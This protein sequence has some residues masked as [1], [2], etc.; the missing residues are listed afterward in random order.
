MPDWVLSLEWSS[1]EWMTA[2]FIGVV[3]VFVVSLGRSM[4][5]V[6][7]LVRSSRQMHR[8]VLKK[9]LRHQYYTS[10]KADR[11]HFEQFSSDLLKSDL[12]LPMIGCS[13]I[14]N[15]SSLTNA[16]VLSVISIPWLLLVVIPAMFL[17]MW[18]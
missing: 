18:L 8:V 16:L 12:M 1:N 11:A 5:G 10:K 17:L 3:V 4:F 14:E 9:M 13:L 15:L 6:F 7:I 2:L